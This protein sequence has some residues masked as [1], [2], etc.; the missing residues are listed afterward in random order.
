M[1]PDSYNIVQDKL[2]PRA[3]SSIAPLLNQTQISH[4]FRKD[5]FG[6]L[7]D[8]VR[9]CTIQMQA[10]CRGSCTKGLTSFKYNNAKAKGGEAT[11]ALFV[12]A[13]YFRS[14]FHF[15]S[16]FFV[17]NLTASPFGFEKDFVLL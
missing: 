12:C 2:C 10:G 6:F 5:S 7:P 11:K 4:G 15:L 1:V 3:R 8:C 16:L 14:L 17:P 13:Y 9:L